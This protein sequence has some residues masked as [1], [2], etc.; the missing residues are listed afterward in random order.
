MSTTGRPGDETVV[1]DKGGWVLWMLMHQM[2]RAAFLDGARHFIAFYH[3][4]PDHPVLQDFA[5]FMRPYAP[6]QAGVRRLRPPVV[7]RAA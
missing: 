4:S 3:R 2:G 5:A 1:Y 6:D 7:L